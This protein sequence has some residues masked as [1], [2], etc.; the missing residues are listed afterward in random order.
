MAHTTGRNVLFVVLDTVRKDHLTPYGYELATT[1]TLES[2]A[3]EALVYEQAVTQAPWTLPAH[4]SMFTGRYPSEHTAT[5]ESPSL[6]AGVGTLA[7]ALSTAGYRTACFSSNAWITPYTRLTAGF[8]EHD[9][10]FE[11]LPG[12]SLSSVAAALWRRLTDGRLRPL[13]DRLVEFGNTIHE[14]LA[15]RGADS[16]TP[17]V[18]DRTRKFIDETDDQWFAFANL[19]DAHLPYYPPQAYRAE[20]AP[21][22]DPGAV[23]QNSKIHNSGACPVSEAEFESIRRLYDAE[24]RHMD[25][26]LGRLF[27]YLRQS[28]QWEETVVIVCADHGELHGEFDLYGHEFAVY[29]PLVN[30]PLLVKHPDLG[31]GRVGRT[32]ELLD[33][34]DTVL[35]S[36]AALDAPGRV[37]GRRFE[38]GRSLCSGERQIPDPKC[39]FVEYHRPV[40]ERRQLRTKARKAGVEIDERSRFDSRMC[41]VRRPD[42]MYI[43]NERIP[44]EAYRLDGGHDSPRTVPETIDPDGAVAAELSAALSGFSGRVGSIC[45]ND[46]SSSNRDRQIPVDEAIS[47]MDDATRR[48]LRDL[49]YL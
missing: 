49:G 33:L 18:L 7:Q 32:V 25:A 45:G 22:V 44:D 30:V 34:Y 40:I 15:A 31:T 16:K 28:G 20:F 12:S 8:D 24:I 19:M 5:Q 26:E 11:A 43:H 47:E 10:F 39:G 6:P 41:A 2:F 48:R 17:A 36:A 1:P 23:C 35:E 37:G 3:E 46:I 14:R 9:S 38:P 29:D 4:A 42:A 13:A 21:G 27:E